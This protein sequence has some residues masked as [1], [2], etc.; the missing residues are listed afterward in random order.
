[1]VWEDL[2]HVTKIEVFLNILV[3]FIELINKCFKGYQK[4]KIFSNIIEKFNELFI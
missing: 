3:S 1:M 2:K 4:T